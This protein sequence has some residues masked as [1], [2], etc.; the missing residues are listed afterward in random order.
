M[1]TVMELTIVLFL[2]VFFLAGLALSV[3]GVISLFRGN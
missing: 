1:N 3:H 2:L